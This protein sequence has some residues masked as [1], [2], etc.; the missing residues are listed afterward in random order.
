LQSQREFQLW[1]K[2]AENPVVAVYQIE[3]FI[4]LARCEVC[5][6]DAQIINA[7]K[8]S[9]RPFRFVSKYNRGKHSLK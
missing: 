3:A 2:A 9:H 6:T 1:R 8:W 7:N 4:Y 5:V